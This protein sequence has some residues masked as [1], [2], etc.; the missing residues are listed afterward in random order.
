MCGWF[1][2]DK[3]ET[4]TFAISEYKHY[5]ETHC[6][7]LIGTECALLIDTGLG[8]SNIHDVV[9]TL[10]K[11]PI[12]VATTHVHWDHIGGHRYFNDL[13]VHELEKGWL[14]SRFPIPL[15]MIKHNLICKPCAFPSDFNLN[16]YQIF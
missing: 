9:H 4:D 11:L 8:V 15:E 16:N 2:V 13:A 6:Y 7:L 1:T 5:E 3:I 12:I 10:T 14:D